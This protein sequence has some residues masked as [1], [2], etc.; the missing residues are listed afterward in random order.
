M[1]DSNEWI[2]FIYS[3]WFITENTF[4]FWRTPK[5]VNS[6]G[7][8][9]S[10][11]EGFSLSH[12][13]R[14]LNSPTAN[15]CWQRRFLSCEVMAGGVF[16]ICRVISSGFGPYC[17]YRCA[18]EGGGTGAQL[19]GLIAAAQSCP[20]AQLRAP[21]WWMGFLRSCPGS[22][23]RNINNYFALLRRI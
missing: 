10:C 8:N 7:R 23:C 11:Q 21:S 3:I 4:H 13:P 1:I 14:V 20:W 6:L 19:W 15:I 12:F 18:G 2:L 9:Q 22:F 17:S 16:Y 5:L